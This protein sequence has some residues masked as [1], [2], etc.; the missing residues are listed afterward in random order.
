MNN[1]IIASDYRDTTPN[2]TMRKSTKFDQAKSIGIGKL[3][4]GNPQVPRESQK[5]KYITNSGTSMMSLK[6]LQGKYKYA[7]MKTQSSLFNQN[8]A[9]SS[10]PVTAR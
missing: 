5:N 2:R 1:V 9:S 7:A 4:S 3:L 8:Q 6:E 10:R